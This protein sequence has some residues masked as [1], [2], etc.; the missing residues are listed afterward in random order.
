MKLFA[1][2][3]KED[4]DFVKFKLFVSLK[5]LCTRFQFHIELNKDR[6]NLQKVVKVLHLKQYTKIFDLIFFLNNDIHNTYKIMIFI[7]DAHNDI[8]MHTKYK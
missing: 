3:W 1:A 2:G 4:D 6:R 5:L 7:I 8:Y